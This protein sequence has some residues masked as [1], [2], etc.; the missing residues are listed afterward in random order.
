[1]D[2]IIIIVFN[3]MILLQFFENGLKYMEEK[4]KG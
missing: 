1:M 3:F 4:F 2:M